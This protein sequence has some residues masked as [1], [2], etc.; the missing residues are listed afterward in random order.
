[1]EEPWL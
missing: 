1:V